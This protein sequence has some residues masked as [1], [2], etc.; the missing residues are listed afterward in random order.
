VRL[1]DLLKK[2]MPCYVLTVCPNCFVSTQYEL[3]L[4]KPRHR[5]RNSLHQNYLHTIH[6]SGTHLHSSSVVSGQFVS[7][8]TALIG[9]ACTKFL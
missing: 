7:G 1:L 4:A 5:I 6:Y 9:W 8:Y 3:Y 2:E